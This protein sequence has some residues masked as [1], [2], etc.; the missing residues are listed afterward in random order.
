[1]IPEMNKI[2]NIDFALLPIGGTYTMNAREAATLAGEIKPKTVIPMHYGSVAD[3]Q[4][5]KRLCQNTQV[6]I[7]EA[8]N[9]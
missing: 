8:E 3:A 2:R 9:E 6:Q 1:I 7:Q 5:F 4:E